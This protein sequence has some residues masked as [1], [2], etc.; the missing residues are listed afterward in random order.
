VSIYSQPR[1]KPDAASSFARQLAL[2]SSD[3]FPQT[4][5]DPLQKRRRPGRQ[6]LHYQSFNGSNEK[7]S[8]TRSCGITCGQRVASSFGCPPI[9]EIRTRRCSSCDGRDARRLDCT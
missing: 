1:T 6:P 2:D 7:R 4:S 3:I 5:S 8:R 9:L